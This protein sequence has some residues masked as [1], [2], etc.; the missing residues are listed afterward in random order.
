MKTLLCVLTVLVMAAPAIAETYITSDIT[1]STSWT[2]AGSPYI[3][4]ANVAVTNNSTLSI[5]AGV[6]VA[7]DGD[8]YLETGWGS[9][10]IA[11][12][13]S[14]NGVLFTSNAG[15]PAPGNWKWLVVNGPNP[16]SLEYCTFEFAEQGL[17]VSFASPTVSHCT[18]RSCSSSGLYIG[19][20]SPTVQYCDI[21]ACRDAIGISGNTSNPTINFNNIHDNTH[22]NI[23]VFSYPE[24]AVTINCESNW[25]GTD[26]EAEIANEINDSV[27]NPAIYATIDYDPWLHEVPVEATSWGRIKALFAD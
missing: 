18:I 19:E 26:V 3:I 12:G 25:W 23:Y 4:Q 17:R 21:Y 15:T 5:E 16:S 20:S 6:T 24:P 22:W 14:G 11:A 8:Y 9:A 27:D 1:S 13:T 7:F 2:P 10:I